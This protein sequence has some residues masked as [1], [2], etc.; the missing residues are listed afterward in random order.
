[1]FNVAY[2]FACFFVILR[3]KIG[4][5]FFI[6]KLNVVSSLPDILYFNALSAVYSL[7]FS[8]GLHN[9]LAFKSNRLQLFYVKPVLNITGNLQEYSVYL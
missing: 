8:Y 3:K 1:M 6:G 9:S 5:I 4:C 2:S 7:T